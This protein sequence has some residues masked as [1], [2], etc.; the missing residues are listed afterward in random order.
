MRRNIVNMPI[1]ELVEDM[2]IYPRHAVDDGN[3]QRLALAL[4][5]GNDLPPIVADSRSKRI[6]DGWHRVRA[7]KRVYGPGASIRVELREF[8]NEMAIIEEAILLNCS[9]GRPLDSIDRTRAAVML[10]KHGV[11]DGRAAAILN[12]PEER[13]K[14]VLVK[15]ATAQVE[16]GTTIPGTTKITLKRSVAHLQGTTLTNE[17]AKAHD[18]MPGTSFLLICRQLITAVRTKPINLEDGRLR[19]ELKELRTVLTNTD[20]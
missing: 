19:D 18:L 12:M 11:T 1:C 9:H 6:V 17:Q 5:A 4:E 20:L 13:Y 10:Q 2:D 7:T 16:T 3:I 8:A 15:V 14:R